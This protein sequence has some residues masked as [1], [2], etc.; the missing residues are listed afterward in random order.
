MQ[1]QKSAKTSAREAAAQAADRTQQSASKKAQSKPSTTRASTANSHGGRACAPREARTTGNVRDPAGRAQP[2]STRG[3][4]THARGETRTRSQPRPSTSSRCGGT[5]RRS[6]CDERRE[7]SPHPQSASHRSRGAASAHSGGAVRCSRHDE[8]HAD[9]TARHVSSNRGSG[10]RRGP[11]NEAG[12]RTA[13]PS[14]YRTRSG[15][16]AA[17]EP[18]NPMLREPV[19]DSRAHHSSRGPESREAQGRSGQRRRG[20]SPAPSAER[21]ARRKR[22]P[23]SHGEG[24]HACGGVLRAEASDG[25]NEAASESSRPLPARTSPR[26]SGRQSAPG[27]RAERDRASTL[28]GRGHALQAEGSDMRASVGPKSERPDSKH[29]G[30]EGVRS[31]LPD[32]R[33]CT[34]CNNLF[35]SQGFKRGAGPSAPCLLCEHR[36]DVA[37]GCPHNLDRADAEAW[38]RGWMVEQRTCP[39]PLLPPADHWRVFEFEDAW[40]W[41]GITGEQ[42]MQSSLRRAQVSKEASAFGRSPVTGEPAF[43]WFHVCLLY[44]SPSPRD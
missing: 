42:R 7:Q 33:R 38:L 22:K 5:A 39:W 23:D 1:M 36:L 26:L 13:Q 3:A 10:P 20:C 6:R 43:V 11:Q 27:Q 17:D 4:G 16:A 29:P 34:V 14:S 18:V 44:T 21:T 8:R 19:M 28:V 30:R 25:A 15:P 41:Q 9:W 24:P 32:L 37:C 40:Y 2:V 12:R 31:V 35:P